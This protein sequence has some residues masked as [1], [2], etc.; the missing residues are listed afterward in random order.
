VKQLLFVELT[1]PE[2]QQGKFDAA[3]NTLLS[4]S[5]VTVCGIATIDVRVKSGTI[6]DL[7]L[8]LPAQVNILSL[9]APSLRTHK[10]IDENG[11]QRVNVEFTQDMEG[12]FRIEVAYEE[13]VQDLH[14]EINAPTLLVRGAEVEQGRIAVEA[15]SAVEVLPAKAEQLSSLD[16]VEPLRISIPAAG[17]HYSFSKLYANQAGQE[18]YVS[19]PYSRDSGT[20]FTDLL[21]GLA[22]L[23]FCAG[24]FSLT[25]KREQKAFAAIAG[26]AAVAGL[27]VGYW[28]FDARP[29]LSAP[30]AQ[31]LQ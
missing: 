8:E 14:S 23:M 13:I 27:L 15:L 4:L 3:V 12:E 26:G 25:K 9:S 5:D 31:L 11:K 6:S 19:L 24:L 16:P 10:I 28:R 20:V 22:T 7:D 18:P 30:S 29:C 17:V 1:R 21:S 2:K